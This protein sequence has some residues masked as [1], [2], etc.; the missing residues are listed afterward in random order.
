M[1]D[2]STEAVNSGYG[3]MEDLG[4]AA[5]VEAARIGLDAYAVLY[6]RYLKRVYRYTRIRTNSDQE[7]EDLTQE[8][9]LR[10]YEALPRYVPRG[11]P[12]AAWLMRIARN[13]V[14]DTHRRRRVMVPW[15]HLP[16]ATHP[17]DA[18]DM[19]T[20]IQR[21]EELATLQTLLAQ[22][23]EDKRE[24]V[25]LRFVAELTSREIALVVGKSHAAVQKQLVRTLHSLKEQYDAE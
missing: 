16:E 7:A 11:L 23:P 17:I 15:D 10:A 3:Y 21:Q 12:F 1:R 13:H 25:A 20:D 19:F 14:I 2:Y 9:F 24:L 4:D 6:R 5:L 8:I 22:L 18:R